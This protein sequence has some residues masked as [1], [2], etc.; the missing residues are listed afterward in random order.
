MLLFLHHLQKLAHLAG[1]FVDKFVIFFPRDFSV[2]VGVKLRK[3]FAGFFAGFFNHVINVFF[4]RDIAVFVLV[5]LVKLFIA[6]FLK[7]GLQLGKVKLL[8]RNLG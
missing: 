8:R 5:Q 4:L 1:C 3:R 6:D 7:F 2:F